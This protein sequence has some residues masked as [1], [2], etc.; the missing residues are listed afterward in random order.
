MNKRNT[1]LCTH[2]GAG[3]RLQT[4]KATTLSSVLRGKCLAYLHANA[5]H[6]NT[7][8]I[9]MPNIYI[10]IVAH[11]DTMLHWCQYWFYIFFLLEYTLHSHVYTYII[12][13]VKPMLSRATDDDDDDASSKNKNDIYQSDRDR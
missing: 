9:G 6:T 2:D 11:P 8:S 1:P 5:T 10:Y 13:K 7:R 3:G 12:A 4:R